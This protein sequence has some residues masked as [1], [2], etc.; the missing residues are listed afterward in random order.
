[1][2]VELCCLLN[3]RCPSCHLLSNMNW[4]LLWGVGSLQSPFSTSSIHLPLVNG[5]EQGW[6]PQYPR[7]APA[8]SLFWSPWRTAMLDTR[9]R[10]M[11]TSPSPSKYTPGKRWW[12][13]DMELVCY[14]IY[15]C[16]NCIDFTELPGWTVGFYFYAVAVCRLCF[17]CSLVF[18]LQPHQWR[19]GTTIPSRSRKALFAF[20][21]NI[22][23]ESSTP[24]CC[25]HITRHAVSLVWLLLNSTFWL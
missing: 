16:Y 14:Q 25:P 10:Q 8:S 6:W 20:G 12:Y 22:T 17:K 19:R 18:P 23:G 15:F 2:E 5:G 1:M 3:T 4:H 9:S 7:P 21:Q 13:L 24:W 11:P